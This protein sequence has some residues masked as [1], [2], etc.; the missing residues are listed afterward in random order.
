LGPA[1]VDQRAQG[2]AGRPQVVPALRE[3]HVAQRGDYLK[4]DD[5]LIL[6]HQVG[7][8]FA[9]D[10]VV[11]KD[12]DSPLL[13]DAEPGLSHFVGKGVF[14]DLFNEPMTERIGDP[15]RTSDDRP[16]TGCN[17]RASPSSICIPLIR[18]KACLRIRTDA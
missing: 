17:N 13:D 14:V 8:I 12:H 1:D 9:G 18:L 11:V 3:M 7:S 16:V 2:L 4:F 5:D 15:E 6:D 10:H